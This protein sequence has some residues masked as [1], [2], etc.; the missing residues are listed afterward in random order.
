MSQ[1]PEMLLPPAGPLRPTA[2]TVPA[3]WT[4][5]QALAVFELLDDLRET[6][7]ALCGCQLQARLQEQ[8]QCGSVDDG[9]DPSDARSF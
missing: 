3:T 5:E 8:L 9:D 4:P 2:V 6:V 7:W 1:P